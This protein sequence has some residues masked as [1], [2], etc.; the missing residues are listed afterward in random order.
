M[1]DAVETSSKDRTI[2]AVALI[3]GGLDSM[4][5][6]RVIQE[7]GI[8]VEGINFFTGF[9]VEGHTHAIR[10][11]HQKKEK[12]NNALWV[13]E[14]LG[15]KLHIIDVVEEYKDVLLNPAHG[16]GK[17]MNPCLDC[18]GF[19]VKKAWQWMQQHD[20]DFIITG[21][22]VGQRPM[23]QRRDTMPVIAR[24]SGSGDRL[25]RPLSAKILPP[26]YPEQQG[27]VDR[28]KL[29]DFSGRTRKPQM[30][31]AARF[32]FKGYASPAGGCCM[33]TDA[34]YSKKL[35]DMWQNRGQRDYQLDDIIMLKVGR[36]I[37]FCPDFKLII[38][39]EMGENNFLMG[40]KQQ[41]HRIYCRSH[42]GPLALIDGEIPSAQDRELALAIVARY[43]Q[44]RHEKS[45]TMV[46]ESPAGEKQSFSVKP[47]EP[48]A[49]QP[50]WIV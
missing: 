32:G 48:E 29:L 31:L 19:M 27:W 33:L 35:V 47:L 9:C 36:H 3:S 8:H 50:E 4:L 23:S 1:G 20:F 22:V 40:Y 30:A 12:R 38:G 49:I 7:Q 28:D 42:S 24:E 43:T 13:A 21:E 6:V 45:V 2:R 44:G 10:K 18:K 25:L 34:S 11:K 39:R 16:Y 41:F 26:T 37:R 15:I 46:I 17:N 14:Q 5:A